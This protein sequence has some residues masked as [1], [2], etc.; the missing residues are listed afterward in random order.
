MLCLCMIVK[1]EENSLAGQSNPIRIVP[2]TGGKKIYWGDLH[3]H[4]YESDGIGSPLVIASKTGALKP[5]SGASAVPIAAAIATSTRFWTIP[6]TMSEDRL[7][8]GPFD[9]ATVRR[10]V[11]TCR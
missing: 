2:E 3:V 1:D 8:T 10:S 11:S 9:F 7:G 6:I 4:S 5:T